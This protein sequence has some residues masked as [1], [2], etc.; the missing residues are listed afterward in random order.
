MWFHT[1]KF[2]LGA[3]KTD[4]VITSVVFHSLDDLSMQ[5]CCWMCCIM[6]VYIMLFCIVFSS[7][8][9][10][11]WSR[12]G[13]LQSSRKSPGWWDQLMWFLSTVRWCYVKM[14]LKLVWEYA[15]WIAVWRYLFVNGHI[16]WCSM[17]VEGPLKKERNIKPCCIAVFLSF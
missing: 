5:L 10:R 8:M 2:V 14:A 12:D 15:L 17:M 1:V 13:W 3:D 11:W 9:I 4:E 6:D 16:R 7:N